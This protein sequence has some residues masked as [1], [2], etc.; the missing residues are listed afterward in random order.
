M[1]GDWCVIGPLDVCGGSYGHRAPV[2]EVPPFSHALDEAT[3]FVPRSPL[4]EHAA[5][6]RMAILAAAARKHASNVQIFGSVARGE[7][8]GTSDVDLLVSPEAKPRA[9][10]SSVV[11]WKACLDDIARRGLLG[12]VETIWLDRGYD[13]EVTRTRLVERGIDDA[14]IAKSARGEHPRAR[15]TSRWDCGGPSN[16]RTRGSATSVSC[17]ATP[18]ASTPT[19]WP[20]SPWPSP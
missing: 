19:A 13:S 2:V 11:T 20:N 6:G 8:N 10:L 14:V 7:D 3:K 4:G 5:A 1:D 9:F 17:A 15:S 16:G 12:D 18:T